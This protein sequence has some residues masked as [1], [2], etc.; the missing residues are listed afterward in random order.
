MITREQFDMTW[1]H[2]EETVPEEVTKYCNTVI[3][4]D[5]ETQFTDEDNARMN[6]LPE[7]YLTP[8]NPEVQS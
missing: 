5:L 1:Q 6:R 8:G 4:Y 3:A 2:G 7:F